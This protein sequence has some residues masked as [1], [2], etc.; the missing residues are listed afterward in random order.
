MDLDSQAQDPS[1]SDFADLDPQAQDPWQNPDFHEEDD[2]MDL[3]S[4]TENEPTD[5][6]FHPMDEITDLEFLTDDNL[7]NAPPQAKTCTRGRNVP[8]ENEPQGHSFQAEPSQPPENAPAKASGINQAPGRD[9]RYLSE[10]VGL[11]R[12]PARGALSPREHEI[13]KKKQKEADN[14]QNQNNQE[15][16]MPTNDARP[17]PD[18]TN[19]RAAATR[20]W[21][22]LDSAALE[23]NVNFLRFRLPEHCR[24]MPAV[25]AEAYGHGAVLMSHQLS[26]L[27]VDAF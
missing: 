6:G 25:K 4:Q 12:Q 26:R 17:E 18:S 9:A 27:G 19:G 10:S 20:A 3:D 22:E 11:K 5:M 7:Q 1:D 8:A 14:M 2:L 16:K 23:Q 24:L 21:I 13:Q 15:T